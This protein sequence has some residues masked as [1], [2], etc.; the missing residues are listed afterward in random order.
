MSDGP[1][2]PPGIE[3]YCVCCHAIETFR[4]ALPPR[5]PHCQTETPWRPV[6]PPVRGW[7]LSE[8]DKK[9]LKSFRIDAA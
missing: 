7:L 6:V 2:E 5:C 4:R 3:A 9:M 1:A 8:N